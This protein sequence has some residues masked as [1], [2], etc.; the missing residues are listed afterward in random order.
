[1]PWGTT[2]YCWENGPNRVHRYLAERS[3]FRLLECG[4]SVVLDDLT[5]TPFAVDHGP[6]APG[7]VGFALRHGGRKV[8]LTGDFLRVHDEDDPLFDGA[9]VMFMDAN[10]WHPAEH[11]GH[12]S[13]LGN[14]RRIEKW[15]PKRAYMIHYSGYEDRD[16]PHDLVNSPMDVKRFRQ[17]LQRVAGGQDIQPAEHGMVLGDAA[18][19]PE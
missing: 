13:V 11:T 2:A 19:W 4:A 8:I 9:D 7:A 3:D 5:M 15:R 18:P 10:T 14:L 6:K 1:M 16:H 12:Q 17:E